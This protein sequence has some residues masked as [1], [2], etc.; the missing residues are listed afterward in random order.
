[1][2]TVTLRTEVAVVHVIPVMAAAAGLGC[3]N[4]AGRRTLV[5]LVAV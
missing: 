3:F 5:T 1:M 4:L 2:A